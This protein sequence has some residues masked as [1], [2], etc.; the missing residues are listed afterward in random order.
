MKY[1]HGRGGRWEMVSH[2][3]PQHHTILAK[4]LPIHSISELTATC[5][6]RRAKKSKQKG[7]ETTAQNAI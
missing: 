4:A 6:K 5:T 1:G 2:L 7:A 3:P